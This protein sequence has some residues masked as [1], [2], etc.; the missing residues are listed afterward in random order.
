MLLARAG[1]PT[2][3]IEQHR[4]PRDKVCG[5]CLSALGIEV[6]DRSGA[7][8]VVAQLKPVA[9]E[10]ALIHAPNGAMVE[11][12]LPARMWGISR[13]ALDHTLLD[14][15]RA[16]GVRV[17]QPARCER[18]ER[19][20]IVVRD[21]TL[22]RMEEIE[23]TCVIVAD[24][25]GS[26]TTDL[27]IKAH[28]TGV[29][30]PRDAIELF[31]V[32]G[33]YGGLAPIEDGN[34]NASFSVPASRVR[35]F[36]GDLD[37]MFAAIVSENA[38]LRERM[39]RAHRTSEWIASPLARSPVANAWAEN[40]IPV[41]NAAASL[42]PI[43]GEGMGLAM[44]SAELAAHEIIAAHREGRAIDAVSLHRTYRDLWRVR[45]LACRAAAIIVSR[46]WLANFLAGAIDGREELPR[47]IMRFIGK[48]RSALVS[49]A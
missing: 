1:V 25:K 10:R 42:E 11:L 49:R 48:S 41:G 43:G 31:G 9:L 23:T 15:A 38:T 26:P 20:R 27:G 30:G 40:V 47:T 4:L 22:N 44:R 29:H 3:L 36:R 16:S 46:P 7:R 2:I 21:L 19:N 18:I 28:F 5:E 14:H 13:R 12:R 24:G 39:D 8:E 32:D 35:Q 33:H 45:S 34:W 6:L 17:V 37:A